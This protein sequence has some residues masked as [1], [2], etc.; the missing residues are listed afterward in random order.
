[1]SPPI[2]E[3]KLFA[4]QPR[5]NLVLRQRL[6]ERLNTG[7]SGKLTLVSAPAGFGK[8]TAVSSWVA[9]C[10]RD[11]A[12]LSLDATD[13]DLIQFF[14]Y[15]IASI[16]KISPDFGKQAVQALRSIDSV[17]YTS[18]AITILNDLIELPA[19]IILVLDDFHLIE[20]VEVVEALAFLIEHLPATVHLVIT[21]RQEPSFSLPRL[22]VRGELT[23][24]R[25]ADLRFTPSETAVFLNQSM[26]LNLSEEAISTLEGRTEGW[27]AGLQL[28]AISLQ[29][30]PER[31][32]YIEAFSGQHRFVADYLVEE[33]LRTQPE[34]IRQFLL[35]TAHLKR[36][37]GELCDAITNRTDGKETLATLERNNLF[38]IPLDE[39]RSWYRY[40]H[41]FSDLLRNQTPESEVDQIKEIHEKASEWFEGRD[42]L[43]DAIYHAKLAH[44]YSRVATLIESSWDELRQIYEND[45]LIKWLKDIPESLFKMHPLLN[46]YYALALISVDPLVAE[47]RLDDIELWLKSDQRSPEELEQAQRQAIPGMVEISR[48]FRA[49]AQG[50]LADTIAH[51]QK[52]LD[53]LPADDF[54]WRGSAGAMLGLTY[55]GQ[56][57]ITKAYDEIVQSLGNMRRAENLS[58]TISIMFL[59]ADMCM[60]QLKLKQAEE[61]CQ[62]AMALVTEA[63]GRSHQGSA[64]IQVVLS[65][66]YYERGELDKAKEALFLSRSLGDQ[67][68]LEVLRHRWYIAMAHIN[69]VERDAENAFGNLNEGDELYF[70]SPAPEVRPIDAIR[71]RFWVRQGELEKARASFTE[72]AI[73]RGGVVSHIELYDMTTL[74]HFYVTERNEGEGVD[75]VKLLERLTAVAEKHNRVADLI[76]ILILNT[77]QTQ[78]T[79]PLEKALQLAL[80]ESAKQRFINWG[81]SLIPYLRKIITKNGNLRLFIDSILERLVQK[82]STDR[83]AL[84]KESPLTLQPLFE[85]LSAREIEVLSLMAAGN[86]NQQIANQLFLTLNTIKVHSRNIYG[87]LDVHNRTQAVNRARGLG[88]LPS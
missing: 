26:K 62:E 22:R 84:Q 24:F 77:L 49:G 17:P 13:N 54:F 63:A 42:F 18:L 28:A 71:R 59:L 30:K 78:S 4:P 25:T 72:Q 20:H 60:V 11:V 75:V 80:P 65:E 38:L 6:I 40:H 37:D 76:D 46:A 43:V 47:K 82:T 61:I 50:N 31:E 32:A 52:A 57:D 8:T 10:D 85:P 51:S 3:T 48:A 53:Y 56:G 2:L 73:S 7:L 87:K 83:P 21:T 15:L 5:P 27:I 74:A 70:G 66:I 67:A 35:K 55:W 41:L 86:T 36:F 33:V 64:N 23:E 81:P 39:A 9:R 68:E 88:L 14:T 16:Q 12:W 1:M 44:Q 34:S 45:T 79:A 29:N 58:A 69:L 19:P